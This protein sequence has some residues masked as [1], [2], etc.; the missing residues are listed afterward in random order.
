MHA[1][2]GHMVIDPYDKND[3]LM[4][5]QTGVT[6]LTWKANKFDVKVKDTSRTEVMN[7]RG[8]SYPCAEYD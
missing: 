2:R 3:M 8:T 7:V 1:T 5:K 6:G 4:S